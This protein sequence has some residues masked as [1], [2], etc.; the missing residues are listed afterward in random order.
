MLRKLLYVDDERENLVV[1]R[2]A[3]SK[4]FHVLE[5]SGG[6]EALKLLA[7]HDVPVVVADQR[8]PDM[9][10]VELCERVAREYPYTVRMILTGYIDSDA[11]MDAINKGHVYNF[12]TKP[13]ERKTLLSMLLRAVEVHDLA[14]S[15]NALLERVAHADRC[16]TLG[17]IAA[18]VAHEIRNQLFI[19]PL[20]ELVEVKYPEDEE[21]MQFAAAA[22]E[23]HAR[24]SNLVDEIMDFVRK[25]DGECT[26]LPVNL[27]DLVREGLALAAM[28]KSIPRGRLKLDIRANP[29]V[30]GHKSRL[31]QVLFNLV[32]NAGDALEDREHGEIRV[33]VDADDAE[34][35]LSVQDD[36]PGIDAA[37]LEKIWEPFFTTKGERGNG[38][39]LDV[40]RRIIE[41][42]GGT[43]TG[44]NREGGGAEFVFRLPRIPEG[45]G[46]EP[47]DRY[48]EGIAC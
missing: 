38:L 40:C 20:V 29:V 37:H 1:F 25:G 44:R 35:W 14:V 13:W 4:Y 8:M 15:N 2:A 5:A 3:F 45:E 9:T 19:L 33:V 39:G 43:M 24:L 34:A 42:H 17:R 32:K 18:G 36:G 7:A 48:T 31:Q 22:R 21:L 10:G 30:R 6:E 23:T 28:D 26:L 12:V 41:T 46:S 11:M 47:A 16:A 27:A